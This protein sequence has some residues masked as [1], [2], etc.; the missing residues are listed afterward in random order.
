VTTLSAEVSVPAGDAGEQLP[1]PGVPGRVTIGITCFNA[2]DTIHRA[3]ESAFLQDWPDLEVVV[4]DDC[5]SDG[6]AAV[7]D[8]LIRDRTHARLVRHAVNAGPGATRNTILA[9]ATGEFVAFFDDD[10]LSLPGRV[11]MQ[12]RRIVEYEQAHG[13]RQLACFASGRRRYP[14]GYE[15]PL[16]AIGSRPQ[17]PSGPLVADY[18]LFNRREP[19]V[20]YG[21]GTPTC[22]LMARRSTFAA[23]GGFDPTFRRVE[24][25]DFAVRLALAGGHF[26]GC[27]DELFTQYATVAPDKTPGVNVAAELQLIEKHATYLRSRGRYRYARQWFKLRHLHFSGQRWRFLGAL[28]L[29]LVQFPIAGTRHLLLSAPSRRAH[30]KQMDSQRAAG[31]RKAT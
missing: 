20:F 24:D 15:L 9:A 2:A 10:D 27:E 6:S 4:A 5:S 31:T 13:V 29:F 1:Q 3:L 28:M 12:V 14:N 8:R 22:A 25:A 7:V 19:G 16:P 18:L 23:L 11:R 26:I 30:E 21:A 17:V